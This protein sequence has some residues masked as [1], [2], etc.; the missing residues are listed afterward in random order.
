MT[1]PEIRTLPLSVLSPSQWRARSMTQ[2]MLPLFRKSL[3]RFGSVRLPVWNSRTGDLVDGHELVRAFMDDGWTEAQAIVVDLSESEAEALHIELHSPFVRGRFDPAR[4][5]E[6]IEDIKAGA[7]EA[8]DDLRLL[9]IEISARM[10]I[11]ER[12]RPED[13]PGQR[14]LF[15]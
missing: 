4:L 3:D 1:P 12:T 10:E 13:L 11:L 2:L 14:R 9:D 6:L 8:Y 7:P 15:A 5:A